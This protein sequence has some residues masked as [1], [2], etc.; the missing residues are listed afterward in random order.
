LKI[1]NFTIPRSNCSKD[2]DETFI[3]TPKF[4]LL[5]LWTSLDVYPSIAMLMDVDSC[6]SCAQIALI[7]P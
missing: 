1:S 5:K 4:V 6:F 7:F 2:G 3:T